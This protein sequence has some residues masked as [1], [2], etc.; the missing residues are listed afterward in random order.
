[1]GDTGSGTGVGAFLGL[2]PI[3]V[4]MLLSFFEAE[5]LLPWGWGQGSC[6]LYTNQLG[7]RWE[8]RGGHELGGRL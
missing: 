2:S 3:A 1:M 5:G 8:W 7:R 6:L 4:A